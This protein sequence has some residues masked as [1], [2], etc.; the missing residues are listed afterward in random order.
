MHY[1]KYIEYKTQYLSLKNDY[2]LHTGGTNTD[3]FACDEKKSLLK[4]VMKH[5]MEYIKQ[6]I[7]V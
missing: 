4:F 5:K 7:V 1:K 3:K 6:K 2:K